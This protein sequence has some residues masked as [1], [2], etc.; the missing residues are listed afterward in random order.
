MHT[1]K[2]AALTYTPYGSS[3]TSTSPLGFNGE[4]SDPIGLYPLGN[5]HRVFS[6]TLMRLHSPDHLSPFAQGGLNAYTY[7]LGDPVNL[8]DPSGRAAGLF[9]RIKKSFISSKKLAAESWD[10]SLKSLFPNPQPQH[11]FSGGRALIDE[12]TRRLS[13]V[14]PFTDKLGAVN[15][16]LASH[17]DTFLS[18]EHAQAYVDIAQRVKRGSISNTSAHLAASTEWMKEQG[19]QR[20]VGT[21]FNLLGALA[22]GVEDQALLKTG[23]LLTYTQQDIRTESIK[24]Q[25]KKKPASVRAGKD[26]RRFF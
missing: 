16:R 17:G 5:G 1:S 15:R 22:S 25:A 11:G 9:S 4:F 19:A 23:K 8:A 14:T 21:T 26:L 13:T 7:C 24:I 6:P 12:H 18:S 10:L 2:F 3:P 20:I